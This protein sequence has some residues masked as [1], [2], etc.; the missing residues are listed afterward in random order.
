MDE[1]ARAHA[2]LRRG[3]DFFAAS[4]RPWNPSVRPIRSVTHRLRSKVIGNGLRELDR[5]LNILIDEAARRQRLPT[6][7]RQRNTANKLREFRRTMTLPNDDHERLLALGGSRECLF[8]C[9]GIAR[10]ADAGEAGTMTLGWPGERGRLRRVLL[11]NAIV[12][13]RADLE[14]IGLFY[15][16]LADDLILA[17][18]CDIGRGTGNGGSRAPY[19]PHRSASLMSKDATERCFVLPL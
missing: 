1:L 3:A 19:P 5:F 11:G 12:V 8:H 13:E 2:T 15:A 9:D 14:N 18:T 10:R 7:P 17:A 4:L 16:R 6:A